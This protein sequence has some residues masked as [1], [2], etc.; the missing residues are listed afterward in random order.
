MI[1]SYKMMTSICNNILNK[2]MNQLLEAFDSVGIEVESIYQ[3]K[4]IDGLKLV[5]IIDINKHPNADNLN[6]VKVQTL[7]N[8]F[9]D[10]VCGAK[11]VEIDKYAVLATIGSNLNGITIAKRSIRGVE[12][13]GMLCGYNELSD[14]NSNLLSTEDKEGII[15]FDQ[16]EI[17]S[18]DPNDLLNLNDIVFDLS[19]ASN[20]N[21]LNSYNGI[22]QEISPLLGIN[23]KLNYNL[24]QFTNNKTI[25]IKTDRKICSSV[26]LLT[27]KNVSNFKTS[28]IQKT[29]LIS[30]GYNVYNDW[31]D[32][33]NL[34]S[35]IYNNPIC[36]YDYDKLINSSNDKLSFY[37]NRT[38]YDSKV[39]FNNNELNIEYDTPCIM[40]SSEII[41]IAGLGAIDKFKCDKKTRNILIDVSNYNDLIIRKSCENLKTTNK[42]STLFSK[43]LS[44]WIT[45]NAFNQ[46]VKYFEDFGYDV[47]KNFI[48]DFPI[49]KSI[50]FDYNNFNKFIGTNLSTNTIND[51][52]ILMNFIIKEHFI[53]YHPARLDLINQYD[54]YEEL[55]KIININKLDVAEIYSNVIS[56]NSNLEIDNERYV[57]EYMINN[58]FYEVKTYNLTSKEKYTTFN[59]FNQNQ[60]IKIMNA[61][62]N[63]REYYRYNCIDS[64]IDVLK[65]NIDKKR[66]IHSIF[67]I[68]NFDIN[69]EARN[70]LNILFVDGKHNNLINYNFEWNIFT[71]KTFISNLFASKQIKVDFT[72]PQY[73]PNE[74]YDNQCLEINLSNKTIGYIGRIKNSLLINDYKIENN[75]FCC[76]ID[77]NHL[78]ENNKLTINDISPFQAINRDI[79]IQ[80]NKQNNNIN[81]LIQQIKSIKNV[82]DCNLKDFFIKEGSYI[83][84]LSISICDQ[85]KTL[86]NDEINEIMDKINKLIS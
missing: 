61:I 11:N 70:L 35:L 71:V 50:Y 33:F 73:I 59:F 69:N 21:D 84:T 65:Y 54:L 47:D 78:I 15:L 46:I 49:M 79:N 36:L 57:R 1:I 27:I 81:H 56:L 38:N 62:S 45:I 32:F 5:K 48:F 8:N 22:L 25:D 28:W 67:E 13:N 26:G 52:F 10:I 37:I 4:P 17:T 24:E 14:Y 80:V 20:R 51:A 19:I 77:I 85:T 72:K 82:V 74:I 2:S 66:N 31:N 83:Y 43:P 60:E 53:F 12:S 30:H 42:A 68:Q 55:L 18:N 76:V 44:N 63:M 58:G 16:G 29:I 23:F 39:V 3:K 7:D 64:M 6:I 41:G 9:L 75:C 86:T 34:I 40:N